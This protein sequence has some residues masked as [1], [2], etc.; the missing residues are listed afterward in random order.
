MI[1]DKS[2][3]V[4]KK[5]QRSD[6]HMTTVWVRM[7]KDTFKKKKPAYDIPQ[8]LY[9]KIK[10]QGEGHG[11][12]VD[13]TKE[14]IDTLLKK[15]KVGFVSAGRNPND[16]EDMKLSDAEIDIRDGQLKKDLKQKGFTY[17]KVNGKYGDEE[18]SFMVMVND[19]EKDSMVNL[20]KK[21]NQDS[22]IYSDQGN[23]ELIYTVGDNEGK[24]HKGSGF[25][26]LDQETEDFY[27]EIETAKGK[28][29]KFSLNFD[30]S[31]LVKALKNLMLK[32][33]IPDRYKDKGFT[34]VG[35]KK[36]APDGSDKKWQVLA[37]KVVN[38]E[39]KYKIVSGGYRGMDDYTQHKDEDR[40]DNFWSRMGGKNS[41]K[42]NDPF[43]PL[44]WHKKFGTW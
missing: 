35:V 12:E 3:L 5:V 33:G 21:Y 27:T 2:K 32:G 38:G 40:Q 36:R 23:N 29:V 43:S 22:I 39:T 37:K 42:A 30:F 14:E 18:E 28:K 17:V 25:N 41:A 15:G 10:N 26:L 44:Y 6:G 34:K 31:K 7:T 24:R 20:G 1:K 4:K 19:I 9:D 16:P 11:H 8:E 13:L